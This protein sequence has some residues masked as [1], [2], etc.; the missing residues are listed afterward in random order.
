MTEP[1]QP[2]AMTTTGKVVYAISLPLGLLL[3]VFWPAGSIA[4]RPGWIF[5]GVLLAGFGASA[6]W[7]AVA[8][9]IIYAA[10]SRFQPGTQSWDIK[11]VSVMLA[12][13][14]LSLP[15]AAFDAG[16]ARWSNAPAWVSVAGYGLILVGIAGTAWA[17]VVNPFFEPGVRLQTERH[18][19]VIDTGPYRIVRHPGYLFGWMLFA[20][21][22]LALGSYWALI[23]TAVATVLLI[24]RTRAEDRLLQRGLAGYADY[25]RQ[26]RFRILPGVW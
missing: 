9:P 6:V 16:R 12:A 21:M 8:N 22:P 19:H 2:P 13:M 18:Q 23:P 11:L 3:L 20:G 5:I 10:R 4:W 14:A 15:V 24:V 17:Q 26:V 7:V 1:I 25:A